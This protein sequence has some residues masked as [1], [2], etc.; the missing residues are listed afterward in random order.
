LAIDAPSAKDDTMSY[1]FYGDVLQLYVDDGGVFR[2][3]GYC[4][5]Y[6]KVKTEPLNTSLDEAIAILR[7][8][9]D[10]VVFYPEGDTTVIS[11]IGL[12]YRLVQTL[13]TH[14][15]DVNA[16]AEARP[17]WRFASCTKRKGQDTF[18]M[19]VDAVTGEVLP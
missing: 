10:Y 8:N 11:E 18:V 4:R 7:E 14:D 9:M 2:A 17:A 13:P 3:E 5:S 16:R 6:A 19:F 15:K 1:E 12:C